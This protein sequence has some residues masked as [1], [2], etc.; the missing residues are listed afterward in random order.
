MLPLS[1]SM[2]FLSYLSS[3]LFTA[4]CLFI[5]KFQ[6]VI[7]L[8]HFHLFSHFLRESL[9]YNLSQDISK[10]GFI[11]NVL[12]RCF[13]D[14]L[15]FDGTCTVYFVTIVPW[16]LSIFSMHFGLCIIIFLSTL[17]IT[18]FRVLLQNVWLWEL[19][20]QPLRWYLINSILLVFLNLVFGE[21]EH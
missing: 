18:R 13:R 15:S 5:Y 12:H 4:F 21:T 8:S 7:S 2:S 1:L 6:L 11:E 10:Q 9:L 17:I 14:S 3:L 20:F 16:Y 19:N